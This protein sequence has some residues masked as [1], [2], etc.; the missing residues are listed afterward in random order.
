LDPSSKND[1]L[2]LTT[3]S[4][5]SI[6]PKLHRKKEQTKAKPLDVTAAQSPKPGSAKAPV[7]PATPAL[8]FVTLR[9]VPPKALPN[10]QLPRHDGTEL[11]ACVSPTTFAKLQESQK[12]VYFTPS[13]SKAVYKLLNGPHDPSAPASSAPSPVDPV[14]RVLNPGN[15]PEKPES[16][17][18]APKPGEGEAYIGVLDGIPTG[19]II[20]PSPPE[21]L[22]DWGLLK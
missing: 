17:T 16:K 13:Y 7:A 11:I 20:F 3:N 18:S 8:N 10:L 19:H 22:E 4:E 6:A 21:G 5:V 9:S 12:I 14:P 2:L 1:A 15:A